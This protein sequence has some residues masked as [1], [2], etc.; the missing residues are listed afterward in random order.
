MHSIK[1]TV[2]TQEH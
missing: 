1:L 2:I